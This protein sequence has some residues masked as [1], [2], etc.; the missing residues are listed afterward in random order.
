M[1]AELD[2]EEKEEGEKEEEV[3][4]DDEDS[5]MVRGFRIIL[6][7]DFS[8]VASIFGC[9]WKYEHLEINSMTLT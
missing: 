5:V 6:G 1:S 4:E 9:I 7:A 3:S 2:E 8:W